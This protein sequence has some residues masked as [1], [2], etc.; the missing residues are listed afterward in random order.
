MKNLWLLIGSLGITLVAVVAVALLFTKKANA[1]AVAAD[2]T[3]VL[4]G[5]EHAKGNKDAKITIVEFSDLQCPACKAAQPLVDEIMKQ[6]SES[7]RVVY[8]HFPLRSVHK[9]A[10]AAARASEAAHNQGKFWEMHDKLFAM[11]SDWEGDKDPA[12]H[13]EQYAKDLGL[14]IEQWKKDY[15]DKAMEDRIAK[16]E[17]DGNTLGINS[18]PTFY[19]NNVKT[20]VGDL[21]DAVIKLQNQSTQ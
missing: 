2:P 17:Q 12:A 5:Q 14:N 4:G 15:Q 7:A 3:L 11:Q 16:D 9:N 10:D 8:R 21:F 20:E 19:V 13:F 18:T 6:A 1:P